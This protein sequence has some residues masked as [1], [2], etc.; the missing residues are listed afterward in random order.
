MDYEI[1]HKLRYSADKGLT[2]I[3]DK[4]GAELHDL[5]RCYLI[6]RRRDKK[7]LHELLCARCYSEYE[8]EQERAKNKCSVATRS[9]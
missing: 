5:D 7:I 4:C 6:E 8:E 2:G 9:I 1:V 3:C